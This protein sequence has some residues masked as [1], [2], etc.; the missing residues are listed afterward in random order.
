[1]PRR[2]VA[3]FLLL[4]F[5]LISLTRA[6]SVLVRVGGASAGE[7]AVVPVDLTAAARWCK[8]LPV[9][10]ASVKALSEDESEVPLQFVP[11]ADFDPAENVSGI[12]ILKRPK[13]DDGALRL[14]F[15]E[16]PAETARWDGSVATDHYVVHH[17]A[18][19]M[20]GLPSRIEFPST[21]KVFKDFRWQDRAFE[22][23]AGS[24][25]LGDD[26]DA[27]VERISEGPLA[28]VVEVS[29]QY[30]RPD[31]T[32]PRSEPQATYQWFYFH[33][34]PLVYVT[35]VQRQK[36]P[37]TWK[38]VHFLELNFPGKD[39]LSWAGG[40]PLQSGPFEATEK[41]FSFSQ[42]AALLDGDN[43]I[44]AMQSGN[45]LLYDG[46]DG[47][48]TYLHAHR[49]VAWS[50][51]DGTTRQLSA[52]LWI[53]SVENPSH[54]VQAAAHQL[55]TSARA[56]VTV[57]AVRRRIETA[58]NEVQELPPEKRP[59]AWWR[60][61]G[62]RQLEATGRLEAA[63]RAAEGQKPAEWTILTAGN[64]GS[65]FEKTNSGLRLLGL[66]DTARGKQLTAAEPLA[67][68][69][70]ALRRVGSEEER[71]LNAD[72]GWKRIEVTQREQEVAIRWSEA[73]DESLRDIAVIA[74]AIGDPLA[75]AIRWSYRVENGSDRWSV[76]RTVFPQL[77]IAELAA[78]AR[79][80]VPQAAGTL[81]EGVWQR[82]YRFGGTYP[83]GWTSM[84]FM[85]AYD[86]GRGTGLY[87][88]THDPWGVPRICSRSRIP[89]GGRFCSVSIIP[90]RT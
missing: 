3:A 10:P 88:A 74:K 19:K 45:L 82:N 86:E 56:T 1:M 50:P 38:E 75:G 25:R 71:Q 58:E 41:G 36:Q 20:G 77:S 32:A 35:V 79:L 15:G 7:L 63:V 9:H 31:G 46:R 28:T 57:D 6:D 8:R 40:E 55:P 60:V 54:A 52:W 18:G 34:R 67:L 66:F 12:L 61:Q 14:V 78:D 59:Q 76:W 44:G 64:L 30:S 70:V 23:T 13:D 22:P 90:R 53:G 42:W 49:D 21:G 39:F 33:D 87:V 83:G 65:I 80:L 16:A 5:S 69:S 11:A 48:G 89:S 43:A 72:S 17:D 26:R 47:Y 4:S 37:F 29:G 2:C 62:A 51:W 73:A 24:F 27:K 84:Q 81:Q 68:F 85:A